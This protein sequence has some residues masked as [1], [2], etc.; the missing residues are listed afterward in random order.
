MACSGLVACFT[1]RDSECDGKKKVLK[2]DG[3]VSLGS[4]AEGR[5]C[6]DTQKTHA[7]GGSLSRLHKHQYT[8]AAIL[9][10]TR[11][12]CR[13]TTE[14]GKTILD[15]MARLARPGGHIVFHCPDVSWPAYSAAADRLER[16]GLWR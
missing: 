2:R 13:Y 6:R 10:L 11:T 16:D 1:Y 12:G 14:G 8:N 5:V 15:E 9:A 7:D 3:A 4:G